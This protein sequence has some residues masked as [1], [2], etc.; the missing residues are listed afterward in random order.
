MCQARLKG[1]NLESG[2][3]MVNMNLKNTML[4]ETLY[5]WIHPFKASI[6]GMGAVMTMKAHFDS[7]DQADNRVLFAENAIQ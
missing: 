1:T 4:M 6:G 2:N 3:T 5:E 7:A